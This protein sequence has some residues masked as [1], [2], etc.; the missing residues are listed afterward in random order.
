[1]SS[2]KLS[3]EE[4]NGLQKSALYKI[5]SDLY[6]QKEDYRKTMEF[7]EKTSEADKDGKLQST[8]TKAKEVS[9]NVRIFSPF[10]VPEE[11]VNLILGSS[12]IARV[13]TETFPN[14]TIVHAYRGS[15]T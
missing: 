14:D 11:C 13:K 12:I 3:Q 6:D 5:Y 4:F 2:K 8:S 9:K 15:S 10:S 7:I 1:M